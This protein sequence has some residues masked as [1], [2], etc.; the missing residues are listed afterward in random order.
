M[1]IKLDLLKRL[2]NEEAQKLNEA[3]YKVTRD[4][5]K[6]LQRGLNL[7][8]IGDDVDEDAPNPGSPGFDEYMAK[9]KN[10][11][12]ERETSAHKG[13]TGAHHGC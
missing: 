9:M 8:F 6:T 3:R 7:F 12:K 13:A 5:V 4:D 1:K 2:I 10:K 11:K